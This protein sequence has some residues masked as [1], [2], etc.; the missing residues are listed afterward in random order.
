MA[1][2]IPLPNYKVQLA[3]EVPLNKIPLPCLGQLKYNG[4]RVT[5]L[6]REF[7]D[8]KFVTRNG[9]VF[10][11]PEL[12]TSI[13]L[14]NL[15]Y[16]MLDGELCFGN[17]Q[18]TDHTAVSGI[19]NSALKT[20]PIRNGLPLVYNVFD[21][22]ELSDFITQ[23]CSTPYSVRLTNVEKLLEKTILNNIKVAQTWNFMSH[24]DIDIKFK[25]LLEQGFEGMIL[26]S[27]QHK[28][29][30][31]RSKD[32]IKLKSI[33]TADLKCYAIQ[34]GKGKYQGMIGALLCKGDV[35]GENIF[36]SVGSGLNDCARSIP[37]EHY[38]GKTIE[39]KYNS[40]IQ[41]KTTNIWSLFLPRYVQVRFDK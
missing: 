41:D 6:I 4:V 25:E 38:I 37:E 1:K 22:M 26:K 18:Y 2:L 7:D 36:V 12:K 21:C 29:L 3:M 33:K 15:S 35:E 31:K 27:W 5:V 40:I 23:E 34:E 16:Y 20:T 9:L 19:V 14:L 13:K 10:E 24:A 28:Y 11:Y 8:I 39:I 17:S 30:F 32:W